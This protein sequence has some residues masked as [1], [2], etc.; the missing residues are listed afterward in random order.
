VAGP[1]SLN[2]ID[3]PDLEQTQFGPD[4]QRWL[5]NT[6]D[7]INESLRIISEAFS[8]LITANG[9]D[10]GGAGAGPITVTVTGLTPSGFVNA[11]LISS[12]NPVTILS[13][14][15]GTNGFDITF[16]ADPGASAIIVYQAFTAQPQ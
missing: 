14:V 10:V 7:S 15:P 8:N 5:A 11:N 6:T 13:V 3:T 16:S 2:A 4:M 12:S 1:V 9:T